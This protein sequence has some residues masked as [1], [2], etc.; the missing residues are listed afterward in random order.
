VINDGVSQNFG[1]ATESF[2]STTNDARLQTT[3][4]DA[5]VN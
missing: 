5:G 3:S 2:L 4:S 1:E